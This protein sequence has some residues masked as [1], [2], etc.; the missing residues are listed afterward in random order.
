MTPG[1]VY[2]AQ[3]RPCLHRAALREQRR[4]RDVAAYQIRQGW[5]R[6]SRSCAPEERRWIPKYEATCARPRGGEGWGREGRGMGVLHT[7]ILAK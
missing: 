7:P 4:R 3:P 5:Q 2:K 6:L 1:R